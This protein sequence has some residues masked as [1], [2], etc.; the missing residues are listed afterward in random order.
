MASP[1]VV[2]VEGGVDCP[3]SGGTKVKPTSNGTVL[4]K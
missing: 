1:T 2:G 4:P 3:G